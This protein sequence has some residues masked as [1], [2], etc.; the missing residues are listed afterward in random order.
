[1]GGYGDLVQCG[2]RVEHSWFLPHCGAQPVPLWS[3]A[4]G[5]CEDWYVLGLPKR[6]LKTRGSACVEC[7]VDVLRLQPTTMPVPGSA[8]AVDGCTASDAAIQLGA[9]PGNAHS[10]FCSVQCRD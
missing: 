2:W 7:M 8:S 9:E 4:R 1:M 10:C 5:C 3:L 6:A